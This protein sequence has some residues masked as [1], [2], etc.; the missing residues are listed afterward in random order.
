MINLGKIKLREEYQVPIHSATINHLRKK[1]AK[2]AFVSCSVGGGKTLSIAAIAKHTQEKG[3]RVLVLARQGELADQNSKMAWRC[4]LKNS[5][6]SASCGSKS[7]FY[8]VV[9]GTE[10]TVAGA[11]DSDFLDTK[12]DLLMIDEAHMVNHADVTRTINGKNTDDPTQY[13]KIIN[14]LLKINPK[15]RIIGYTGSPYR[16]RETI[17]GEFWDSELYNVSTMYLVGLGYLVPPVFGFGDDS[18]KYDLSEW[19]T[20][21]ADKGAKDYTSSELQAMQRKITKDK[22]LTQV[23]IEEVVQIC[24]NRSGGVMI[25]CAGKKHCEQ[26]AELLP[27]NSWAI[28]TDSTSAKVRAKALEDIRTGAIKYIIQIG[29]LT[30]G[31]NIPSLSTSVIMRR[32]GSLTLLTQLVGRILRTLEDE[33]IEREFTKIDGLVLDY[34][35]TFES[36]GDIYDDP[37][38]EQAKAAKGS[39]I[40][41]TQDCPTCQTKNSIHAV[42]CVGHGDNSEGRCDYFFKGTMCLKCDT[43]N[44]PTARNCRQCDVILIDPSK[45]LKNKAYSDADWKEVVFGSRKFSVT[46]KGD[47]ICVTYDLNST[48]HKDGKEYQEAAKEYFKPFSKAPHDANKWNHFIYSHVSARRFV[49]QVKSAR[50]V[51]EI[52]KNKAVFDC[53]THITHRINESYISIINRRKFLSGREVK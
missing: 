15:M 7:T 20:K 27:L 41:E 14:H 29:C 31:I 36:F 21:D 43:M 34:S 19:T 24:S 10:G 47:G 1:D 5:I 8:P 26:V 23:I 2:P 17:I 37:L 51:Q 42:R 46:K 48:Y 50:T 3:G 32:I 4:E 40:N 44:A 18:H 13:A 30:T 49:S 22:Q 38:L 6:Y 16:G 11:L 33:D 35:D 9:F 12:Y 25:T 45:A 52:V 28:V 53:P 39:F